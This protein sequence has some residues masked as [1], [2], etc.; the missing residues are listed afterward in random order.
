MTKTRQKFATQV[1]PELLSEVRTLAKE[2]GRN[3]QA[4]VEEALQALVEERRSGKP[5]RHVV[6]AYMKSHKRYGSLYEKL[7]K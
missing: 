5:R 3:I 1:D 2:E 6:N 4:L 7:A